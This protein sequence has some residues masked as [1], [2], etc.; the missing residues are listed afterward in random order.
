M[1]H[2]PR[3]LLTYLPLL[4]ADVLTWR[5]HDADVT[6][7]AAELVRYLAREEC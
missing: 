7:E 6:Q 5:L 2:Y 1:M 3:D 4:R